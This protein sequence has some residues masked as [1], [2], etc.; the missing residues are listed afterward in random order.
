MADTQETPDECW[1]LDEENFSFDSLEDLIACND[2]LGAG[3]EVYR[4]T[5]RHEDPGGWVDADDVIE[6]L[7]CRASDEAG[8]YADDYPDISE[9]A[10]DELQ[11]FLEWWARRHAQPTFYTVENVTPYTLTEEDLAQ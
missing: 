4:G 2:H 6:N 10:K 9:D 8:E 11:A 1:S 5:K 7:S 3:D